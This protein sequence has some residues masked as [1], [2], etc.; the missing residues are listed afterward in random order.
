MFQSYSDYTL[1]D[2]W[3]LKGWPE[4]TMLRGNVVMRDGRATGRPG[5]GLYLFRIRRNGNT[6]VI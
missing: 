6:T 4:L 1:Y 3:K 5:V 2:G